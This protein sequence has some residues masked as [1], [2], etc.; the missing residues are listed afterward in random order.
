MSQ[1]AVDGVTNDIPSTT[2]LPVRRLACPPPGGELRSRAMSHPDARPGPAMLLAGVVGVLLVLLPGPAARAIEPSA[3]GDAPPGWAKETAAFLRT[4]A[5]EDGGYAWPDQPH[6]H[7][8]PTFAAVGA[9]QRLGAAV[10]EPAKVAAFVRD[11]HPQRHKKPERPLHEFDLQ[12]VQALLWLGQDPREQFE[13][14]ARGWT[15]PVPYM[16]RYESHQYPAFGQ[17]VACL[18]SRQLLKLPTNLPAYAAYIAERRRANGSYNNTLPADDGSDGH[19]INTLWAIRGLEALGRPIDGKE[20][21]SAWLRAC[22]RKAGGHFGHAPES[23]AGKP[24]LVGGRSNDVVYTWAAVRALQLL[25]AAPADADAC[26]AYLHSLRNADGGFGDRPGWPSNALATYY[27]VDAL[28]A[29]NA[30]GREPPARPLQTGGGAA[31]LPNPPADLP[32]DLKVFTVQIQAPGS[33]SPADAVEL[34]RS[35]GIHL[36]G[37]K[38]SKPGWIEAAQT[39]ADQQKVPVRFFVA[40]EEYNTFFSVPGMGTY[41]HLS[42]VIAPAGVDFGKSLAGVKPAPTWAEFRERRLAPLEQAGGRNV[43]QF[44]E[45]EPL[46]RMLLD[47][48]ID[49]EGGALSGRAFAAV[50]T[51]HFGNPNFVHS[52]PYLWHYQHRLPMVALQDSH[53]AEPWLWADQ[54]EGFRTL[55]LARE[56]TWDGWMEA[57]RNNWVASVRRDAVSGG[58]LWA[59]AGRPAV[60]RRVMEQSADWKWWREAGEPARPNAVVRPAVSVAVLTPADTFEPGRPEAGA[61]LRIRRGWQNTAQG[62]PKAPSAELVSVTVDGQPAEPK[63]VRVAPAGGKNAPARIADEYYL[64]PLADLPP[65]KHAATVVVRPTGEE[66][67]GAGAAAAAA[68]VERTVE[69]EVPGR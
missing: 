14:L 37:A 23:A 63:Q 48:S 33:G 62:M 1:W 39:L 15:K 67:G 3:A 35:L 19:V 24:P 20:E 51:F 36:W 52:Q 29:L 55:F 6:A 64:V 2:R 40:N 50:S 16:A 10:P 9:Y 54:L 31:R 13:P 7:L 32:A 65:G 38:N 61:V 57:V 56:P 69:F 22:Q 59:H 60:Q 4:L 26:V 27:A 43:Y 44:N 11:S 28:A 34:A 49:G 8:T 5:R 17:E 47:E 46:A 58:K 25:G 18:V 12:Q 21:T 45:N 42:D 66:G 41:S 68:V 53:A 30:L